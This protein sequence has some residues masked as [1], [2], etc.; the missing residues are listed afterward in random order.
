MDNYKTDRFRINFDVI[1]SGITYEEKISNAKTY[2]TNSEIQEMIQYCIDKNLYEFYKDTLIDGFK[3][4]I[5]MR[6]EDR[7]NKI[8][9]LLNEN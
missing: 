5:E 3:K 6:I 2:L 9:I 7:S 4:I 1:A 8:N